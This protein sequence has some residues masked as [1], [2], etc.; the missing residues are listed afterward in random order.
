MVCDDSECA[1][2]VWTEKDV[3]IEIFL[4]DKDFLDEVIESI[5]NFFKNGVLLDIVGKWYTRK[6]IGNSHVI[7]VQQPL[8]ANGE[9]SCS[10]ET[11][12]SGIW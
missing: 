3:A 4:T 9:R 2:G 8:L 6:P 12:D 7:E 5:Q 10:E 1:F 11:E